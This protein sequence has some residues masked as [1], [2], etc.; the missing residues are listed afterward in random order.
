VATGGFAG[1]RVPRLRLGLTN[2]LAGLGLLL[3]DLLTCL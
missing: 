1:D 3:A 2:R